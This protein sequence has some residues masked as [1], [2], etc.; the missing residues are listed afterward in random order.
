[1][2]LI[3][4]FFFVLLWLSSP[5]PVT[6]AGGQGHKTN[7]RVLEGG[8]DGQ[9]PS[10]E[11]RERARNEIRQVISLVIAMHHSLSM[12]YKKRLLEEVFY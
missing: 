5:Q 6:I 4:S 1:M 3:F 2:N 7:L 8:D 11:E 12:L 10:V 9:C